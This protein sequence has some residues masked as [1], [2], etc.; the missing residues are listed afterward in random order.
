M[1]APCVVITGTTHGIGLHT[2]KSIAATGATVIMLNRGLERARLVEDHVRKVTAN[3][4]VF[5][6][7]GD[8][9]SLASVREATLGIRERFRRIDVLINN[10]GIMSGKPRLSADGVEL[11]FATN[12]LGPFLL[13]HLL[14]DALLASPQGRVVNVASSVHAMGRLDYARLTTTTSY[15]ALSAYAASKLANVMTTLRLAREVA[16]S[17][18]TVNCVHPGVV[19]TNLLPQDV[20]LL[21]WGGRLVRKAMRSAQQSAQCVTHLACSPSLA[22]VSGQ[23]FSPH[24]R[25][26]E[27]SAAA[28]DPD[29]QDALWHASLVLAGLA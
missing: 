19:A 13:T 18:L 20:P 29:A 9:A 11:T 6:V 25:I 16:G 28:R 22:N 7:T 3:D 8:L 14:L 12:H 23:Y 1:S 5:N 2:A 4:R 27:P 24:S 10:A 15:G 26:I 21:R 17:N